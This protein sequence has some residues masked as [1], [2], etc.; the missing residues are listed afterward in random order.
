VYSRI[1]SLGRLF[2]GL[3]AVIAVMV[4]CRVHEPVHREHDYAPRKKGWRMAPFSIAVHV[5]VV[6]LQ[7]Q[8]ADI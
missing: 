3:A 8:Q 1:P 4:V 2:V 5:F 6:S 7:V